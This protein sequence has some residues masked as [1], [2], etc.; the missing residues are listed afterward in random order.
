MSFKAL[1]SRLARGPVMDGIVRLVTIIEQA[2]LQSIAIF[3]YLRMRW[4]VRRVN[5]A[6][7]LVCLHRENVEF[8]MTTRSMRF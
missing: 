3:S 1:I 7:Y 2:L 6:G 4:E 8:F 5:D